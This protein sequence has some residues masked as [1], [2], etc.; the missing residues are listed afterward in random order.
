T[1]NTVIANEDVPLVI[2]AGNFSFT[3]T[4]SDALQSVTITGLNLNGGTLT[5]SSGAVTVTNGMTI[6]AAQLADLTFTSA[7]NDST[8][9]SFTYTVNDADS[10]LTS[11]IMN[12]TVNA[13]NDVPV[14]TG[15]TVIANE[16]V[17]LVIG[18]GDFSFTDTESDALTSV[19]ITGLNLNGGTLTHSSGAVNVTNGMTVTA[20]QLAD[21]TFTSA[22]DNFTD[23]SFSYTVNDLDTGVTS[24]L[25]N[26]TIG[27]VNDVPVITAIEAAALAYTENDSALNV[28][29]A[30]TLS[31]VDDVD[32]ESASVTLS[33]N[34]ISGEDVLT[35]TDAGDIT[36]D[37]D[38]L[39]GTLT[40]TGTDTV[41]AYQAALRSVGYENT[42]NN[43]SSI[44][45]TLTIVVN[46]GDA[47]SAAVT[48]AIDV[49]PVNDDSTVS[50]SGTAAYSENSPP[51]V[52]APSAIISD[53]DSTDFN[54]GVLTI[55]LTSNGHS[56]D[57][58]AIQSVGS[59]LGEISTSGATVS[60]EGT[61]IGSFSGGTDGS[62]PLIVTLNASADNTSVQA[63]LRNVTFEHL[64]DDPVSSRVF[65]VTLTDGDG[66][67]TNQSKVIAITAINDAPSLSSLS[68]D[69]L[70]AINDG[71]GYQLDTNSP[72]AVTDPDNATDFNG[73][74]L[75]LTGNSFDASDALGIDTGGT[76]S[77]SAGLTDGSVVSV[78]GVDIG[79]LSSTSNSGLT[80]SFNANSTSAR[81]DDLLQAITYSSSSLTLG[82]RSVDFTFNDNDGTANGG[83]ESSTSSVSIFLAA[84]GT[85]SVD[86]DEDV[87]HVFGAA[88][89]TGSGIPVSSINS[90]TITALPASGDL[91]LNGSPVAINTEITRT[92]LDGNQLT[93]VPTADQNGT[94][95]ASLQFYVNGG[96]SSVS[97]LAGEHSGYT[98]NGGSWPE[99]DAIVA[100][101]A[102]FGTGGVVANTISV[103][104]A[105]NTIDAAYLSQGSVLINGFVGDG[106][107]TASELNAIDTWVQAG[108]VLISTGDHDTVDALNS[109][110]GLTT[111]N[112]AND[113]WRINDTSTDIINGP[114]GL[115][116]NVGDT[117]SAIGSIASFTAASLAVGDLIIADD[118]ITGDPTV[119]LRQHGAGYIL[120]TGD[121]GIFRAS[122][123]GGGAVATANDRLT[124]NAFAWASG[125]TPPDE[126][127]DL[128]I[129][130][131]PVNDAPSQS[132]LEAATM[133][134]TEND[135]AVIVTSALTLGDIDDTHLESA[136][137]SISGNYSAGE[138]V[139]AFSNTANITGSFDAI[140]G[141]LT[142]TGSDLVA[143]YQ[144]A[145]RSVT[146]ENV[147]EDPTESIRSVSF[148]VN[149]GDADSAILTRSIDIEATNDIPV[150]S[151]IEPTAL[152]YTENDG[153]SNV[154]AT[155]SLDDVDDSNLELARVSITANYVP[156]EDV[157][158][159][160]NTA[161]LTGSFD[162][163]TGVLT[164]TGSDTVAAYEA[165]LRSIGY[166]NTSDN[167]SIFSRVLTFVVN[168]GDADSAAITRII[169]VSAVNDVPVQNAIE[170]TALDYTEN[171]GPQVLTTTLTL[172]DL[173]DVNLEVATVSITS[174]YSAG[175]DILAFA[176]T[177]NITGSFDALTGLLILTG[178]DTLAA[179][180]GALR[181]VTY[182][183]T[184]DDPSALSRTVAF[185]VNDG[186]NNS[187][188]VSRAIDIT[189]SNDAPLQ[190]SIEPAALDYT[191]NDGPQVV[192]ATLALSDIDDLDLELATVAITGNYVTGEDVL[193][194]ANTAGITGTFDAITGV[195][196]LSGTDTV[197]AYE[198]AL[199]SVRYEN[200]SDD[201]S[202]ISRTV[203]FTVN[204]GDVDS[205]SVT[206]D[207][208][209]SAVN[210]APVQGSIEGA[211][212]VY[213]END[214]ALRVTSTL[215]LSDLDDVDLESASVSISSNYVAGEDV[216]AFANTANI[217]GSFDALTG[218]LTLTGT[219]T[220][221]AYEAALR[222]ITYEN[223]SDDP[224]ALSRTLS[225]EVDDG[226]DPA[227]TIS[228]NIDIQA[229]NDTPVQSAIENTAL[230]YTENDGPQAITA[231]LALD[232]FDDL[233]LESATVSITGNYLAG[234]DLLSFANTAS[235][236]GSFNAGTGILTLTGT[237]TVS[238]Y[239]A[240]LRSVRYENSSDDPSAVSRTVTF[241]V[242]DGD[243]NSAS[244]TRD[245][246]I[247]PVN[248]AP[249]QSSIEGTALVYTENDGALLVTSTLVLDDL[250]DTNLE[251]ASVSIS[252]NYI[253]GEDVLSFVNTANISGSFDPLTGALA[254]TGTDTISAYEAALR[255]IT[256]ENTSDD[257][258]SLSRTLSFVV[259]DGN[260]DAAPLTRNIDIQAVNDTPVQSAIENTTL[261]YTE[262]DGPLVIT[263]TLAL[264]DVDDTNLELATVAITGNYA[265]G[266]DVLS[267][268]N[269]ASITGNFNS[270]TGVLTLTGS[271]TVSA[272]EA[273]LRSV[274]Y[275]NI[276]DDPSAS[277]RTV[278]FTV[279]DGDINSASVAREINITPVNDPPVLNSLEGT[280]L[281]YTENDGARLVT[282]TLVPSDLD[283]TV[284]E[285]ASVSISSNYAA[286]EDILTFVDTANI[287]GSF[288]P[289]TGLLTLT[290][291]DTVA[292]YEAALQS[293]SYENTSDD[294][295]SLSRTLSFVVNDGNA[296]AT[297]VT[298]AI[299]VIAVNDAPVATAIEPSVADYTEN[300]LP[301][302]VTATIAL[303][304]SDNTQLDSAFV[305]ITANYTPG[306][307]T[308][309]FSDTATITGSFNPLTGILSLSG[310]DTL[311]AYEA[312]LRSVTYHNSSDDP[313][314][315]PR[316]LS[317]SVNDGNLD[318]ASIARIVT[319]T[320]VNDIPVASNLETSALVYNENDGAIALTSTLALNEL[321][322]ST[323][324]RAVITITDN[325]VADED[326]LAF[327]DTPNISASWDDLTG[328][329]TLTGSDT[330][331]A[332]Q[333]A[334]RSV[335]YQNS[336]DDLTDLPRT[337][338]F[339]VSDGASDSDSV[340]RTI[341]VN[342]INDA[343]VLSAM[344]SAAIAYTENTGSV[345][346]SSTLTLSDLDDT[347]IESAQVQISGNY[348]VGE[349]LLAFT[350]TAQI[351]ASWDPLTGTLSLT[352]TATKAEYQ[353]ALQAVT[354]SNSSDDPIT[355]DRTLSVTVNDGD[356]DSNT[357]TRLVDLTAI[358]DAPTQSNIEATPLVYRENDGA[359]SITST[360]TFDDLDNTTLASLR[361][362]ISG[363]YSPAEDRLAFVGTTTIA[364]A[365]DPLHGE[366]VLTGV[367]SL[368]AYQDAVRA[369]SYENISDE[370]N[371]ATRTI[372]ITAN[373]GLL[374]SNTL[375][376]EISLIDVNDAPTASDNIIAI[377]EDEPYTLAAAD[378]GFNDTVDNSQLH[379]VRI[380]SLPLAGQLTVDGVAVSV[381]SNL[382][383]AQLDAGALVYTPVP[384]GN[385]LAHATFDFQVRDDAG[386]DNGGV[387]LSVSSY[388]LTFDV[389]A[390]SDAPF[391]TDIRLSQLE[392]STYTLK[393]SDFGFID[394]AD[395]DTFVSV[396]IEQLPAAGSLLLDGVAVIEGQV[397][398]SADIDSG[399]LQF[400]PNLNEH[401][402]DYAT[403]V[404][405]VQDSGTDGGST[406]SDEPN[407]IA[408]DVT[409]VNDAP[410]GENNT[411]QTFEDTPYT[412]NQEDFGFT[413]NEDFGQHA[414]IALTIVSLPESGA[415]TVD[416]LQ[417]VVGQH[418][419]VSAIDAG[420]LVYTPPFNETGTGYNGF[421]F[422]VH[423]NG[424]KDNDGID[425]DATTNF[426]SFDLP[427]VN[428]PPSLI[429][430]GGIV[431]EGAKL[432][433]TSAML[434]GTDAD[435]P[436]PHELSITIT[437]LPEHGELSLNG[438]LLS[439]GDQF[440]LVDIEEM[441]L[442]YQHDE[443]ETSQDKFGVSLADGGEN[444]APP[445][446]GD[447]GLIIN[448]V[449]D[450]AP[451]LDNDTLELSFGE[452]FDS[453][454]G[455][456][457][458]SGFS[459]LNGNG[460]LDNTTFL[461]EIVEPP[462]HGTVEL[463]S[464]G[465]FSYIHNGSL[466]LTDE[467]SYRVTNEDG[468][469]TVATVTI[470][471]EPPIES[472]FEKT[473]VL[474]PPVVV[475]PEPEP[476]S[477]TSLIAK[478]KA[479]E[480]KEAEQAR[481]AEEEKEAEEEAKEAAEEAEEAEEAEAE[482]AAQAAA[483]GG[484]FSFNNG[485]NSSIGS[486][487]LGNAASIVRA[488][489]SDFRV[490]ADDSLSMS[491]SFSVTQH[492]S[493]VS[494]FSLTSEGLKVVS[495]A[496]VDLIL[497]VK[498]SSIRDTISNSGFIDSLSQLD[499]DL[500]N[501][502]DQKLS[503]YR[504]AED[505]VL[506]VSFSM[507]VGVVAWAL[508]GGALFTSL[509]AATPIWASI[510]ATRI[511]SASAEARRKE[512]NSDNG[513]EGT[514]ETI[515]DK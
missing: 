136:S 119:V 453:T 225:F 48:R 76:V 502:G 244:V 503:R 458:N 275:E 233:N 156:G 13:V 2:G 456:L 121:E 139:L 513:K 259:N 445:A 217:S 490:G 344:E 294:P 110:F 321:D 325:F 320:P 87:T 389:A 61:P 16:D 15:N 35:F 24:A 330:I 353:S 447:F 335:T 197:S 405:R 208:D 515:F 258:S 481:E 315:S 476:E 8:D 187:A 268:A 409:P 372:S 425:I 277:S 285:S 466:Q 406:I 174:N 506:G 216:L 373:D 304:D 255:T 287:S 226:D 451:V 288:D 193:S 80:V 464:D 69:S 129:I 155:V 267:F 88:D 58:L 201:P 265:D 161:N 252:S 346:L 145:L 253:A 435:D 32:L 194:F 179:Y 348:T 205:A 19:T 392:D 168:D 472:A 243:I 199:R 219:D 23:T 291:T 475:I 124:A 437:A 115:V 214:G 388:T 281:V 230:T 132:G 143:N 163:L 172:S 483:E 209:I 324:V 349:D 340:S 399:L 101:T 323:L 375:T 67:S 440:T 140:T 345:A 5:H 368:S 123:T 17:P 432:I 276:S 262:N 228:R 229:V 189:V 412:F 128:D 471:V 249:V 232:D 415:L 351:S 511:I 250:D 218:V 180:Q 142:L 469:S 468:I 242:S 220:V 72:A 134:Y 431:D 68:G 376:R 56:L 222:T 378:F 170:L 271:D 496:T 442:S 260:D 322:N 153:I 512:I 26:I 85:S 78:G 83:L 318:S 106:A 289:L 54:T 484:A 479:A 150:L 118:A 126:I 482:E 74:S 44:S 301:L 227:A 283:D 71:S 459:A 286:G 397:I 371:T 254:L 98:L 463:H 186:D 1:G 361:V 154:T 306:E 416:G 263:S 82:A 305:A 444:D 14:A 328:T 160:T 159:F 133:N 418:V 37:F 498:G 317:F 370:P 500:E 182:E 309:A 45:R 43:P 381:G 383:A 379:S 40:L 51:V 299:T 300:D 7:S 413:D 25:M 396:I 73:G 235:I 147:S 184:S 478:D 486:S 42:S 272:Y 175:E 360:V 236:T 30:L 429:S 382:S 10:G 6:T 237:D 457:L 49:S 441:A 18:A 295:S 514:V 419:A 495:S 499:N 224:S 422:Q 164:I 461:V 332:Y 202:S 462:N 50:L 395:N 404:F 454:K 203:T 117:F 100:N 331:A 173:D 11:A 238:A 428:D 505:T 70:F 474:A 401:G 314:A 91:L 146:Y 52:I 439:V 251:S 66:G 362:S 319:V 114:F 33:A 492:R 127:F 34:Y 365:W 77:L 53:I 75:V 257:P 39:T 342:A 386:T 166:E 390:V 96:H 29:S 352:G 448:E 417:A 312:A 165:A 410:S 198:A 183:N 94:P 393:T 27:A 311:A 338:S 274:R 36:G 343:P 436:E 363:Q 266:E 279:N 111:V 188:L 303:T 407:V 467:F 269:T 3:D 176:N 122:M 59:G 55:A 192:T 63:L 411:I 333:A 120:F 9:S 20:A 510:D 341:A 223:T 116:G 210:D 239:E 377:N 169:N 212:L 470:K 296:D 452:N 316:T 290:G 487:G 297:V 355:L 245:I 310:I 234:E 177:A 438:Q 477:E 367:D 334:L 84:S 81:I 402:E 450:P 473:T 380:A 97:I 138:D 465:T 46:D 284:L 398:L 485:L 282:S 207:I 433:I 493:G 47:D 292:A 489:E 374:D 246:N 507:T 273:A 144:A 307:D 354:Y 99:A 298:R 261:A 446:E 424:G 313:E 191:E 79:S 264:S 90:I 426:I 105:T 149:D 488:G 178:S 394:P 215:A 270:V 31:D 190:A 337:V 449:I 359:V 329:L 256:Y 12:I 157:L 171:D 408:I 504:A 162:A 95:Y 241:T 113:S 400:S 181:S 460:L 420:L 497:E 231:T 385:G 327:T 347:D 86:T 60:F 112:G 38:V 89:F 430:E 151:A 501:L 387:D 308:L 508:R 509:M 204:D 152:A 455:D 384:N 350:D 57:R 358:N 109:Y 206:R 491:N 22:L 65:Q 4:E 278:T 62:T 280:A 427:G 195:L 248:D 302:T 336:S 130:V 364:A 366:L 135:E 92:Q 108:G 293:I 443:S 247:T 167:P 148:A 403:I 21:L 93:Y 434:F 339:R 41:A 185:V 125:L 357:A 423:D 131:N 64:S 369:I 421:G 137:I 102:N 240:A 221:S 200:T 213:T 104:A 107:L 391:G 211:A 141:E 480:A 494:V 196:T 356:A 414:F 103:V 158:S 326:T 28:T